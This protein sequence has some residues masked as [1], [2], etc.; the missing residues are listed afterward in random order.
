[1]IPIPALT[2]HLK[3]WPPKTE[4]IAPM[5][6]PA[7]DEGT[8]LSLATALGVPLILLVLAGTLAI[9]PSTLNP[10]LPIMVAGLLAGAVALHRLIWGAG[11]YYHWAIDVGALLLAWMAVSAHYGLDAYLGQR[12]LMTFA[13]GL[14]FLWGPVC[15]VR[16]Q[17]DWHFAAHV[18]VAFTTLASLQAWPQAI[19]TAI[20]TGSIP[21]LKGTFVN[22][23]TFSVLPL[24]GLTL[25]IGL[26][27]RAAPRVAV[28]LSIQMGVMF[29]TIAGSG[30]RASLLGF[31][32]GALAFLGLMLANRGAR[33]LHKAKALLA[34]PLALALLALPLSNFGF[35][36]F[37][38]YAQTLQGDAAARETTR[39]EVATLG[40]KAAAAR[41]ILGSGPGCFGL[42]FQTARNAGHDR[43]YVNIA[44][45]DPMEVAVE[46]GL[47]GFVLWLTLVGACLTKPYRLLR[48]GR[49]PL[50]AAG[51]LSAVVAVTTYSFFNFVIAERP[52]LWAQL[53]VFGLAL[54][55]PSSRLRCSERRL[56]RALAGLCV[57]AG[58]LAA[59]QFGWRAVQADAL[60]AESH[61]YQQQLQLE[62][63]IQKLDAAITLQPQRPTLRLERAH[64]EQS[65]AAFAPDYNGLPNRLIHLRAA[66]QA[67]PADLGVLTALAQA[68]QDEG[69]PDEAQKVLEQA[70]AVAPYHQE[71]REARAALAIGQGQLA[72]ALDLI[73]QDDP[74]SARDQRAIALLLT[75]EQ[76]KPTAGVE[77][78]KPHL[79][80]DQQYADTLRLLDLAVQACQTRQM[81]AE[82]L[83]LAGLQTSFGKDDLCAA[84]RHA[85]LLGQVQDPA[86]EWKA[87]DQTVTK[88]AASR[89]LC[90]G[91]LVTRWS[92]LG[93]ELNKA[94]QVKKR[95][96]QDLSQDPR[97]SRS[98]LALSELWRQQGRRKEAIDLVRTGLDFEPRS[99]PLLQQVGA[100]YQETG[101]RE[102][103]LNYF[104]EALRVDPNNAQLKAK[105]AELKKG[106]Q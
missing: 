11:P 101:S 77:A 49:R 54:A 83:R 90:Y 103:A 37:G 31:G 97:L 39:I 91:Q 62:M 105:V 75:L 93:F 87:L 21:P 58:G 67:S 10:G 98:R 38:K 36:V 18:F 4:N 60:R 44:H 19:E 35:Q 51:T 1:L 57:L 106:A 80:N 22:P 34:L 92:Q 66:Y 72:A 50:A 24:L 71:V 16:S 78:L 8:R 56:V 59:G 65:W 61:L 84:A 5:A 7:G 12:S 95:L 20:Q 63:A 30:C 28:A 13:G 33:H 32:V 53:F 81:W 79:Q 88:A 68:L 9:Y 86:A 15:F 25:A 26:F 3:V 29:L 85:A 43:L 23:D 52:V 96:E 2:A 45:N 17:K 94:D 6:S 47:P 102:L 14:A 76:Q 27:E 104:T 64:L 40:L 69:N 99:L 74:S 73:L 82:G 70:Q 48:D 41:P 55:I 46:L 100:L 89:D 42:G